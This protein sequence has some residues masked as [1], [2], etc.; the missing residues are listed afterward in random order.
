MSEGGVV[1][2][3]FLCVHIYVC[4]CAAVSVCVC[5]I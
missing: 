4:V 1:S 3:V 5:C 2:C